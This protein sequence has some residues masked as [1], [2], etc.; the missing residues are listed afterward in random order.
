MNA[1]ENK[2]IKVMA[3]GITRCQDL[4][5]SYLYY[6]YQNTTSNQTLDETFTMKERKHLLICEPFRNSDM[7]GVSVKPGFRYPG[8]YF[9][10]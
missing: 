7:F 2:K 5:G 10:Q 9:R 8:L 4:I 1:K 3:E 6:Y